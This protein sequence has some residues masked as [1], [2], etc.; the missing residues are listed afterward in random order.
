MILNLVIVL[1]II[2]IFFNSVTYTHIYKCPQPIL[3]FK[4]VRASRLPGISVPENEKLF[5]TMHLSLDRDIPCGI[6]KIKN[7]YGNGLLFVSKF[8]KRIG[9]MTMR[10]LEFLKG[11]NLLDLWDLERIDSKNDLFIKTYNSGCC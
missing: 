10:D 11:V 2:I 3:K 8:N 1:V 9:Y 6:Y 7:T 5:D 4:Y